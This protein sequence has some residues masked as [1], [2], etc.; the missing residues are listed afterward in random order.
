VSSF[1]AGV[2]YLKMVK[3]ALKFAF[4]SPLQSPGSTR[5]L[6]LEA[7]FLMRNR[8]MRSRRLSSPFFSAMTIQLPSVSQRVSFFFKRK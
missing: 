6:P 2:R 4:F 1:S 3:L 8:P 5:A 7:L